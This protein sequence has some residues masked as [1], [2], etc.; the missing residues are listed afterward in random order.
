MS[1]CECD[2]DD[3]SPEFYTIKKIKHSRKEYHCDECRGPIFIGESY[4]RYAGKYDGEMFDHLECI[5]CLEIRDWAVISMPCFCAY[6]H[7]TLIERV[8]EMVSDVEKEVEGF[9][10]E[11]D[12]RRY[13]IVLRK[14]ARRS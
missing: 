12:T 9:R 8:E 7:G 13:Q 11:W 2:Y 10:D 3:G 14:M 6:E 5:V 4:E 1:Y